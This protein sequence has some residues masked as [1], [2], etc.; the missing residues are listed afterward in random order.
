MT[1]RETMLL[2]HCF[3][4]YYYFSSL[5]IYLSFCAKTSKVICD[6]ALNDGV[7]APP[8]PAAAAPAV[9]EGRCAAA[10][11]GWSFNHRL[12]RRTLPHQTGGFQVVPAAGQLIWWDCRMQGR[13]REK[14]EW[15]PYAG[16]KVW[17]GEI[18][19]V[20]GCK[21]LPQSLKVVY[22]WHS[23]VTAARLPVS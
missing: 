6:W 5:L 22:W 19:C 13:D 11:G 7:P 16:A 23:A 10:E 18:R 9:A 12:Q 2:F 20:H 3:H 15:E 4:F 17:P 14:G 1:P 8:E 21:V